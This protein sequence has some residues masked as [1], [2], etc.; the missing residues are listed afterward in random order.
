MLCA[1]DSWGQDLDKEDSVD[2][3]YMDFSKAFDVVPHHKLLRK[4]LN[5]S[6]CCLMDEELLQQKVI[7]DGYS[8]QWQ[9]LLSG[10]P[11]GSVLGTVL[12]SIYTNDLPDVPMCPTLLL[13]DTPRH[14]QSLNQQMWTPQP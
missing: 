6:L 3:V 10:V 7:V 4:I 12:F 13:A 2:V 8:S 5:H 14:M 9:P 1:L 11:K